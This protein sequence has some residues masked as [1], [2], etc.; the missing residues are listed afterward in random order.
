MICLLQ[1]C[2]KSSQ[3]YTFSANNLWEEFKKGRG[4]YAHTSQTDVSRVSKC[5]PT[6]GERLKLLMNEAKEIQIEFCRK[7][8]YKV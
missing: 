7:V 4:R 8:N 1:T 3:T 2:T 5:P 6:L